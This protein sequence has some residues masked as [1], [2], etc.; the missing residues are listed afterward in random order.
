MKW[1]FLED[2]ELNLPLNLA[3]NLGFVTNISLRAD[4]KELVLFPSADGHTDPHVLTFHTKES[5]LAAYNH[6]K[7]VLKS[8]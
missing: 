5:A 4:D 7:D 2:Y 8:E 6:L 1:I 3:V